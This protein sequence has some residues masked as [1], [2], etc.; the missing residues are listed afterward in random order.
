MLNAKIQIPFPQNEPV[1]DYQPGSNQKKKLK[2]TLADLAGQELEIP[3]IIGGKTIETGR[4]G[5]VPCPHDHQRTLATFHQAGPKEV[6][7]AAQAARDAWPAWASLAHSDRLMIFLR[8]AEL[9]ATKYRYLLV[10]ATMLNQSK[11]A[12]QSEIDAACEVIDF[13]RFNSYFSDQIARY[14][15]FSGPAEFNYLDMRPLEGFVFS[16]TPFNFTA[17]AANLPS[18]PAMLGNVNLWKP[19]SAVVFSNYHLMSLWQ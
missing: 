2:Q 14:Q 6:E 9:L 7:K 5:K 8:A 12:H 19:A 10:A 18:A 13:L 16:V 11:T 4:L 17:I 3:L 15:P 1:F